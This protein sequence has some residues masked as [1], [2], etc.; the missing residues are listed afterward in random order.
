MLDH[1]YPKPNGSATRDARYAR[2]LLSRVDAIEDEM[3]ALEKQGSA[4]F[5]RARAY[6]AELDDLAARRLTLLVA[7]ARIE[8]RLQQ[9]N[10]QPLEAEAAQ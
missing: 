6:L 10:S 4:H 7:V 8:R 2:C 3:A 9:A 1:P 5:Q